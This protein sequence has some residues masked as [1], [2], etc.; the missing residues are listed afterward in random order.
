MQNIISWLLILISYQQQ[1]INCLCILLFGKN[2]K[3]K[4]KSCTYK[5]FTKLSV[6][7]LPIFEKPKPNKIYDCN[8]L[9]Q[10][11]RIKPVKSRGGRVVPVGIVCTYCG[12]TH[13]YI[14]DNNGGKGQFLCKVCKSTFFPFVPSKDDEPHCPFCYSKLTLQKQRKD[15]D[16]F[17]CNNVSCGYRK[18][19]LRNMSKEQLL[20][21]KREPHLFKLRYIFRKF[22]FDFTPLSK[23]NDNMPIVDLPD[24]K[25][26]PHVLG[27]ILTY[28][29]N[30][31]MPLKKVAAIMYDIHGVK[32]SH[33]TVDNYCKSVAPRVKPFVDNYPYE[34]SNS[35][36]GDETYIK[37]KGKW[38]YIF[39]FFDSVKKIIL[40][41]R[42]QKNRDYKSAIYALNDVLIKL[43]EI[44]ERLNLITDGNPIYL[45]AQQWFAQR[46]IL[47]DIT[48]V[49]GLTND[50]EV[51]TEF[52]PLKQIIERLNRTYKWSYN[53]T[54]GFGS[55]LGAVSHVVLFTA[56]YNF[57]RPHQALK[58]SVP[59]VIPELQNIENMPAKWLH[60]IKM[61]E[62][63]IKSQQLSI[64][65]A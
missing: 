39:F 45:L 22:R 55:E 29:I 5:P 33:Q 59:V 37:I 28:R 51:S 10:S 20:L 21:Y 53:S 1:V 48:Q 42:V 25:A 60:L 57:L 24:I 12:A 3:P 46:G 31:G 35:F 52:R 36:C 19:N 18:K 16:I 61:S 13:E 50:D 58:M 15:F 56:F 4:S 41:N 54:T 47:F 9:I 44:P 30:Y 6:D 11:H 62:D 26:T 23:E 8:E 40:S 2:Y 38:N 49:V 27:L 34:L 43:C 63:F 65:R 17:R 14:Y 7:P 32:V 64:S